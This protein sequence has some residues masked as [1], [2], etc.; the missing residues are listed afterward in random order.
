MD[1]K[2]EVFFLLGGCASP[3]LCPLDGSFIDFQTINH[4]EGQWANT[5]EGVEGEAAAAPTPIR[6]LLE[7]PLRDSAFHSAHLGDQML[8]VL[9]II[10]NAV[11]EGP[12]K[13]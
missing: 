13:N 12:L 1:F 7:S 10:G 9:R 11:G 2:A 6:G 3:P 8:W 5:F 4:W